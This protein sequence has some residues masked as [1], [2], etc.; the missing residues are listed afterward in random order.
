MAEPSFQPFKAHSYNKEEQ[1][2]ESW[3]GGLVGKGITPSQR[4]GIPSL[5]YSWL[6]AS[7]DSSMLSSNIHIGTLV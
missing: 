3:Q 1:N 7:I 6:K 4:A 5:E 2:K